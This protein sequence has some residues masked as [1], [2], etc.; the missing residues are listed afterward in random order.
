VFP[1]GCSYIS[2]GCISTGMRNG[3]VLSSE[4]HFPHN[5]FIVH[6][7]R[8]MGMNTE[9]DGQQTESKV[10]TA[11][12]SRADG[13]GDASRADG[14]AGAGGAA[15]VVCAAANSTVVVVIV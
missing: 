4:S 3:N 8:H 11:G 12:A 7:F 15:A 14:A 9:R 6:I 13:V 5:T 10:Q 1:T 2:T